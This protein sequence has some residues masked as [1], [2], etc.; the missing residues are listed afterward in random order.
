MALTPSSDADA[1]WMNRALELA[2][3]GRY[4]A[5]PNP[6]VGA[7]VVDPAGRVVGE[8]FH[9][10][11]GGPHAEVIALREAGRNAHGGSLFVTLEPCGHHGRTPPCVEAILEAGVRRVVIAMR[12]PNPPASGGMDRLRAEGVDVSVGDSSD[13]ARTLNRRWLTWVQERRPWVTMKA[14]TS[15]DGRIATRTGQSKWITGEA[16]RTRGLEL[17]EEHDAILVGVETVIADDPRL[18]RRLG[19][20]PASSWTRIVLDS[21]LRTP[22]D[23]TL[24][25]SEP[26]QTLII[27]TPDAPAAARH[28]LEQAGVQ[29]LAVSADSLGRVDLHAMLEH[30]G[31][32]QVAAL[33]VEGG[34][35][36]HGSFVDA[37]LVDEAVFFV[38][39]LIIG[40]PAPAAVAGRGIADLELAPRLHFEEITRHADDLELRAARVGDQD[41]HGTD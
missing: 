21:Q 31:R 27:H 25:Q 15:L 39:P 9:A 1:R 6:M 35:A 16:A 8:G 23:A 3:R 34:A 11:C 12:D 36:V 4:G 19:L 2:A 10:Q 18:T 30:L 29:L 41:V 32:R 22:R 40:G 38:A 28:D 13:R 26:E 17:R 37:D 5:S 14:A 24:V 33:L 7:V 20:N